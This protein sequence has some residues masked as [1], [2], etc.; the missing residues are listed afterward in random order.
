MVNGQ[1]AKLT[2]D[3]F[4]NTNAAIKL[5]D[6]YYEIPSGVYFYG[7]DFTVSAWVK[8]TIEKSWARLIDFGNGEANNNVHI[9][10]SN[11]QGPGFQVYKNS[12]PSGNVVSPV[13]LNVGEWQ[14]LTVTL[15]GTMGS[16]YIDGN[17]AIQLQDAGLIPNNIS[18]TKNF[19]GKSNWAD[20]NAN[21][22]IDSLRIYNRCLNNE[23][24]SQLLKLNDTTIILQNST[25]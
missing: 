24:I 19:I 15:N 10:L 4:G 1:F 14:Y 20:P 25:K 12:S 22:D 2:T 8:I 3:R 7:G 17:L 5:N 13:K 23:E 11:G 18:R 9:F 21:A 16:I 6:G